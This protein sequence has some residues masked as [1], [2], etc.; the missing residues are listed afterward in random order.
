MRQLTSTYNV[1]PV[2][3]LPGAAG[4][5]DYNDDK[6]S[7]NCVDHD[8]LNAQDIEHHNFIDSAS[9]NYYACI[10][11]IPSTEFTATLPIAN[12]NSGRGAI[13]IS[14]CS[15]HGRLSRPVRNRSDLQHD[16]VQTQQG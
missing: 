8:K 1:I 11:N 6:L 15:Y 12:S 5:S 14:R 16:P 13:K 10:A 4:E 7:N 2:W 9:V 3:C